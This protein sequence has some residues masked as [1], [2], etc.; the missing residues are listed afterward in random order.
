MTFFN[1]KMFGAL[2]PDP[3]SAGTVVSNFESGPEREKKNFHFLFVL[4]GGQELRNILRYL[5]F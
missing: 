4:S 5:I 1:L 3:T 2:D